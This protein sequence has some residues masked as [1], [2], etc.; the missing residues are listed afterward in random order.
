MTD[1]QCQALIDAASSPYAVYKWMCHT[2]LGRE[3][4]L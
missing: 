3:V 2:I 4:Q 1:E